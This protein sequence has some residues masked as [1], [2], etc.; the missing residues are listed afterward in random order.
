MLLR[1]VVVYLVCLFVFCLVSDY[2]GLGVLIGLVG[3]CVLFGLLV[4]L[5]WL[6]MLV[7]PWI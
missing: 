7:L 4:E 2:F 3:Y 5:V 6:F 1:F